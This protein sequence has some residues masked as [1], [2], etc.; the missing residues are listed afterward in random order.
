MASNP[1]PAIGSRV[2]IIGTGVLGLVALK[3]L[4][5]QGL[6]VTALERNDYLGG[7]WHVS[8]K[9]DQVTATTLTTANI[10]KHTNCF[11]DFPFADDVELHPSARSIENYLESYAK[12]FGLVSHI[13]FGTKVDQVE[14]DEVT[15]K[16]KVST[17]TISDNELSPVE[18]QEF[19]RIVMATGMLNK[20]NTVSFPGQ[21][22]FI[23]EIIHSREFKDPYRYTG[24]NILVVGIGATGVDTTTFLKKA[25]AAR[26]YL[27]HRGQTYLMPKMT[28]GK[29]FDHSLS[30][31]LGNILRFCLS[32]WP[33]GGLALMAKSMHRA[34][35]KAYP[36]LAE[37]PSFSK[38]R[39]AP[40]APMIHRL[41]VFSD[42]L[43]YN[44]RDGSVQSVMGVREISGGRS[45]TFT[46]GTVVD[47]LDCIVICSGYHYSFSLVA[48][49]GKPIDPTKAPDQYREI[50][51]APHFEENNPF[52]RL[53]HGF[54]SEQYPES[55]AFL[56]HVVA[57]SPSF[58]FY[59][60]ITM[61][62]ANIWG[63][64]APLPTAKE[65]RQ[66]IDAHYRFITSALKNDRVPHPG[67]RVDVRNTYDWLNK[68]AGTGV[69]ERLGNFNAEAWNLWWSDRRFYNLLMDGVNVPAV[70]RL[71]DTNRGRVP[72]PGA[73]SQIEKTN[74][75]VQ[76]MEEAWKKQNSGKGK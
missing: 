24:K 39:A 15:G 35:M 44:L 23:G 56:G 54:I 69:T 47:D 22:R 7:N 3:N 33:Q 37:H 75:E 17:Q 58:V 60:L 41:P 73:R 67:I 2:C 8:E 34:Q 20:K 71:F 28:D 65:M 70:Y 43:A 74:R 32:W 48:G 68:M 30:R 27:S 10:S 13:H 61:A 38:P 52:S 59:D 4:K 45:V 40:T 9:I 53:Y 51:A 66:D 76:E 16:W 11:T 50:R 72:W 5:E 29:A 19:D 12:H 46:D 55:L 26:I 62:L 14:R 25:G 21:D 6:E 31:R 57:F 63:G 18:C 36:W 1:K 49:A 42:D 64:N